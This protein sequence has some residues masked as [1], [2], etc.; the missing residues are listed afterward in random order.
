MYLLG[1]GAVALSGNYFGDQ[2]SNL[3]AKESLEI[4]EYIQASQTLSNYGFGVLSDSPSK[5]TCQ[6][7]DFML[8]YKSWYFVNSQLK[9][10][11]LQPLYMTSCKT[12]YCRWNKEFRFFWWFLCVQEWRYQHFWSVC[13]EKGIWSVRY[14]SWKLPACCNCVRYYKYTQNKCPITITTTTVR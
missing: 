8:P 7:Y 12:R 6:R 11:S 9:C 4:Q 1:P 2:I 13:M 3:L 14:E 5:D 10:F